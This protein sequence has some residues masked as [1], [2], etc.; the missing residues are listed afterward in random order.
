MAI[1]PWTSGHF[2]SMMAQDEDS[3]G[4]QQHPV[5]N[6]QLYSK[7]HGNLTMINTVIPSSFNPFVI[8]AELHHSPPCWQQWNSSVLLEKRLAK[9]KCK[10]NQVLNGWDTLAQVHRADRLITHTTYLCADCK[11]NASF[12]CLLLSISCANYMYYVLLQLYNFLVHLECISA[13][14]L[15][16]W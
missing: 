10:L 6:L 13:F 5:W 15:P 4:H 7:W 9:C 2:G 14:T 3:G 11:C 1:S 16:H 12:C 8:A